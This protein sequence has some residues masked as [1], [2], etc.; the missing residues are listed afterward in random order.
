VVTCSLAGSP[1]KI[2]GNA[3]TSTYEVA[4]TSSSLLVASPISRQWPSSKQG[5]TSNLLERT[6]HRSFLLCC[7]DNIPHP[8]SNNLNSRLTCRESRSV[9]VHTTLQHETATTTTATMASPTGNA[10]AASASSDDDRHSTRPSYDVR[11]P[12]L[13]CATRYFLCRFLQGQLRLEWWELLLFVYGK[14]GRVHHEH[15]Q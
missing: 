8:S 2:S 4:R 15:Q 14:R 11:S 7:T 5:I 10:L 3:I 13:R 12:T 6:A 1:A 9:V